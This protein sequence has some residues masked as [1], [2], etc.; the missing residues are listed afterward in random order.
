MTEMFLYHYQLLL[1]FPSAAFSSTCSPAPNYTP[2]CTARV[3]HSVHNPS[4]IPCTAHASC[5]THT[6]LAPRLAAH[7]QAVCHILS[8]PGCTLSRLVLRDVGLS[9]S[10]LSSMC[11]ALGANA[12]VTTLDLS[13]NRLTAQHCTADLRCML[14]ANK[15]L[16]ELVL[17]Y[18]GESVQWGWCR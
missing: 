10:G 9:G 4:T 14:Q 18:T 1:S 15:A 13:S 5:T 17:A 2:Q 11:L 6:Q 16:K 3:L 7:I 12:S 8:T